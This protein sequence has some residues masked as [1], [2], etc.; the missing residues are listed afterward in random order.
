MPSRC[1]RRMDR[2]RVLGSC[3][4]AAVVITWGLLT[5]DVDASLLFI[6]SVQKRCA[7]VEPVERQVA[8]EIELTEMKVGRAGIGTHLKWVMCR[9]EETRNLAG[10]LHDVVHHMRQGDERGKSLLLAQGCAQ[11]RAIAWRVVT[12]V[13]QELEIPFEWVAA[14]K[15]RECRRVV[16]GHRVVHAPDH[17]QTVHHLGR[18]RQVLADSQARHAGC[19]RAELA[20][21]LRRGV[22]LHVERID[23]AGTTV[24][25]DQDARTDRSSASRCALSSF[26]ALVASASAW[27][28]LGKERPSEPKLPIRRSWR[29]LR[30][31]RTRACS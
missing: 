11:N 28:N 2:Y 19:D 30:R 27:S 22:W 31:W 8:G 15:G 9:A 14:T 4:F 20:T 5:A 26:A 1:R 24:M 21:D 18:V 29:R 6:E 23:M 16:I 13:A 7:M 25:E 12:V 3:P 17:R 10:K